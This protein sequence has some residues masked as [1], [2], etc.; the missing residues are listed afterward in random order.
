MN[1][2]PSCV[3]VYGTLQRGEKRAALWPHPPLDVQWAT[4]KGKLHDLGDYPALVDGTD[5]VLGE[6]WLIAGEDLPR[7]LQ[8]L[9]SIE[10]F[11]QGDVDLYV[12]QIVDCVKLSGEAQRAYT[13]RYANPNEIA[14]APPV[15]A[16]PEG[17][18]HWRRQDPQRLRLP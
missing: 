11:A 6:L 8:I 16:G 10:G 7:T 18:V 12:R 13:Y 4:T 5:S 3:F 2:V 1:P 9:D 14:G 15:A 17:L